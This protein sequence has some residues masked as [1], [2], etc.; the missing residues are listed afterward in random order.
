MRVDQIMTRDVRAI[1]PDVSAERAWQFMQEERIR[2][3]VVM[4]GDE[5]VGIVSDR[6]LGG[7]HGALARRDRS[8]REMMTPH[9]LA[10]EPSADVRDVAKLLRDLVIGCFP[11]VDGKDL[12]GIVTT[13][14]LLDV[15]ASLS[16]SPP[17]P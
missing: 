11:V 7:S 1:T 9:P 12:V 8:V 10:L 5:V 14:D 13:T 17:P 15:V 16:T 6:D 4:D 3:L 2:H